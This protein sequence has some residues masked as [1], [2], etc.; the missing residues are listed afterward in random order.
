MRLAESTSGSNGAIIV[1][2]GIQVSRPPHGMHIKILDSMSEG[3][4]VEPL[5]EEA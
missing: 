2:P 1:I 5:D 3:N 4:Y